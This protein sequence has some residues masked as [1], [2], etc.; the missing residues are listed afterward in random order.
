MKTVL[1]IIFLSIVITSYAQEKPKKTFKEKLDASL[2]LSY[3]MSYEFDSEKLQKT[4]LILKPEFIYKFNRRSKLVFKSQIYSEFQDNLETGTPRETMVSNFS[5]RLFIDDKT[6]LEL[7]EFYFYT[8]FKNK[9]RVTIGKQQIV[10]GETDGLKLLDIVN[11]QN[12]RRFILEDFEDSRIPLWSVKTEFDINAIGVQLIWIP[13]NTYHITQ[14]FDAPY[15]TKNLFKA[16]P[17]G[18][19]M[20]FRQVQRPERFFK[21]SDIGIKLTTFAKGWDLSLNYLYHYDDLP[22]FYNTLSQFNSVPTITIS[23]KYERQHTLGGTFNKVIGSSTFRGELVYVFNQ[24]FSSNNPNANSAV[25]K[26]NVYKSALGIDYIKG[27]YVFSAQLFNEWITEDIIPF[28]RDR[29]ETNATFLA[30]KEM[31]ND[32]LKAE[33]LWVHS[34][35]NKDGFITPS[36]NYWL[37][38][39][40]Q[41][42]LKSHLFYGKDQFLFGQF[43]NRNNVSFGFKWGI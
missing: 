17:N 20:E 36:L 10:W 35:N 3:D 11:P 2:V 22:V 4:E 8:R 27:E 7:R 30:S 42:I 29:F 34:M 37:N 28:N 14:D 6:S 24:N 31:L 25:E 26:S 12:F 13:D 32:N 21:D 33:I 19:A 5:K 18:V 40:T 1:N 16:L 38:S 39:N 15:F 41:L 9:L 23:P 43:T